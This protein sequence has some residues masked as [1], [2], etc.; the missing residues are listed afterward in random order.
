[1]QRHSAPINIIT[2]ALISC[3]C[4]AVSVF[5]APIA[6]DLEGTWTG[7]LETPRGASKQSLT[8]TLQNGTVG[9]EITSERGTRA[10]DNV[11]CTA[12]GKLTFSMTL[13]MRGQQRTF[14]FSGTL[15]GKTISGKFDM[16]GQRTMPFTVTKGGASSGSAGEGDLI[17]TWETVGVFQGSQYSNIFEFAKEGGQ[18]TGYY[19]RSTAREPVMNLSFSSGELEFSFTHPEGGEVN[20]FATVSTGSMTGTVSG[21]FGEAEVTGKKQ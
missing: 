14:M 15:K 10:L 18:L 2:A 3:S 16:G 11:A 9:G 7:T 4:F 5:S 13:A 1:M 8:F 12:D 19:I 17:G 20:V 6:R 21:Y